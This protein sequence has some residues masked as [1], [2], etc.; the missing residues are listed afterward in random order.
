[1]KVMEFIKVHFKTSTGEVST[2]MVATDVNVNVPHRENDPRRTGDRDDRVAGYKPVEDIDEAH[3][4]QCRKRL[5]R[6][7]LV[8]N[9]TISE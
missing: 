8:K 6:Y 3:R 5:K 9:I 7:V 1:M 2:S 4:K